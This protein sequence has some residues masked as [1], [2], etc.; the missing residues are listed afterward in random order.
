MLKRLKDFVLLVYNRMI[1]SP[2]LD[3][4]FIEVQPT[5][6]DY[7]HPTLGGVGSVE[8]VV[9][10][11]DG[12]W[13]NYLPVSEYQNRNNKESMACV[14]FSLANCIETILNLFIYLRKQG[15]ATK[16]QLEILSIFERFEIIIN[17]VVNISDRYMA[18]M[19]GTTSNGNDQKT[20]ADSTRHNG[21]VAEHIWP[22]ADTE[23]GMWTSNGYYKAIPQE[24]IDKG[25]EL[26]KYI[27]FNYE[28][29]NPRDFNDAKRYSPIQ[30][31]VF[32]WN[33]KSGDIYVKTAQS[34]NHAVE[35]YGYQYEAFDKIYDTYLPFEKKVAWN[36]DLGWGMIFTLHLKNPEYDLSAIRKL[37]KRGFRYIM[38]VDKANGGKGQIYELT[39]DGLV[40]RDAKE[41]T[42]IGLT[43]LAD[44]G[45]FTGISEAD[46]SA[47]IK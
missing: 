41:A 15:K 39:S 23:N 24:I 32:A 40:Y 27:D 5:E 13:D 17:D 12:Q 44:K 36:F 11:E 38:R 21:L 28:W 18:K 37:I 47:L 19:S 7:K 34:R 10:V 30:T 4:G 8:K 42:D 26:M 6:E 3:N 43:A 31:S 46:F 35:N 33:G 29:V 1:S 45:D 16:E 2:Q 20:A 9:L 14:N 22:W 25:K